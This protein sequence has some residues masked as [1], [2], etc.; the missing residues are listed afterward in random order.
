MT[1]TYEQVINMVRPFFLDRWWDAFATNDLMMQYLCLTIQDIYNQ[2]DQTFTYKTQKLTNPVLNGD[3]FNEFT[4]LF[5]IRK[6]YE[7]SSDYYDKMFP[8][9]GMIKSPDRYKFEWNKVITHESIST[10]D[11]V[12]I[13]DYEPVA[14]ATGKNL[15]IPLP[16]RY[17]PVI[18][19][20]MYDWAA[21][22]NLLGSDATSYDFF[23][24]AL[25]R[26]EKI[27]AND[28]LT[29]APDINPMY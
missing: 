14:Y 20:L 15:P 6:W 27:T 7:A 3:W 17:I 4:T 5:P 26:L 9:L 22:I 25:T 16:S 11:F 13:V 8:T 10:M 23:W 1:Y 21:P 18:V 28:S 29:D 19:K 2:N 24:H 12:Y